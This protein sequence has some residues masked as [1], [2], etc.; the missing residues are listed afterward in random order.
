M[1]YCILSKTIQRVIKMYGEK[2]EVVSV[3]LRI[4]TVRGIRVMLDRYLAKMYGV[5]TQNLNLAVKRNKERF[6]D[7]FVFQL[8]EKEVENLRFQFATANISSKFG[9]LLNFVILWLPP[10]NMSF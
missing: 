10:Q 1:L 6:T 9:P 8:T 4:Y 5:H 2:A 3:K 7:D